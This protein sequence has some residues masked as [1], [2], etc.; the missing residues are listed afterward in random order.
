ML[1]LIITPNPVILLPPRPGVG[2][3]RQL[4][5]VQVFPAGGEHGDRRVLLGRRLPAAAV[6]GSLYVDERPA[7]VPQ[8]LPAGEAQVSVNYITQ[9]A[10]RPV[11]RAMEFTGAGKYLM[12]L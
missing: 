12:A 1:R 8:P 3:P 7:A 11:D 5:S 2:V 4:L 6:H 9:S 10:P